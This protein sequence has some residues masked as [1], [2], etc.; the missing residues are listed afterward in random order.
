MTELDL[1]YSLSIEDHETYLTRRVQMSENMITVL[2]QMMAIT[3]PQIAIHL[4]ILDSAWRH[5]IN[6]L[7]EE[8]R[9]KAVDHS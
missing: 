3:N 1:D 6:V 4:K 8:F 7:N 2:M 9:T 5:N